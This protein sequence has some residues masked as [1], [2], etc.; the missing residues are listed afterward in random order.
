MR[1]LRSSCGGVSKEYKAG[2]R[3][4]LKPGTRGHGLATTTDLAN[5][6]SRPGGHG[7]E[8]G[9]RGGAV[10][11]AAADLLLVIPIPIPLI[12]S[13]N[14]QK[15]KEYILFVWHTRFVASCNQVR[16]VLQSIDHTPCKHS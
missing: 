14:I 13:T 5:P 16:V 4:A 8:R 1:N 6:V 7:G 12:A 2:L 9:G 3:E 10:N 11:V 15:I